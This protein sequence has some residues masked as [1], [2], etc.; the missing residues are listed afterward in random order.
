MLT[1]GKCISAHQHKKLVILLFI[2]PIFYQ[3][4]AEI[5]HAKGTKG[6]SQ[7]FLIEVIFT[8]PHESELFSEYVHLYFLSI[9]KRNFSCDI[10]RYNEYFSSNE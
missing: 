7:N 2:V 8:L 9:L 6:T 1:A 4:S 5:R 3:Q 10:E